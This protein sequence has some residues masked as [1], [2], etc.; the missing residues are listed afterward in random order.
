[1]PVVDQR[2]LD[3]VPRHPGVGRGDIRRH[4]APELSPPTIWRALRR[5]A[6][7]VLVD[8]GTRPRSSAAASD[9]TV[10][11]VAA[12]EEVLFQ[13]KGNI[14]TDGFGSKPVCTPRSE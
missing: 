5:L 11:G 14:G 8:V 12:S 9:G 3:H 7:A 13:E 1:M 6:P 10:A 4:V 2:I